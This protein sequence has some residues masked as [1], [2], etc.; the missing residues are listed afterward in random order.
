MPDAHRVWIQLGHAFKENGELSRAEVAY[1]TAVIKAPRVAAG[2]RELA[3]F[4]RRER[5]LREAELLA[6]AGLVVEPD[7]EDL[8]RELGELGVS[9]LKIGPTKDLGRLI[10][11]AMWRRSTNPRPSSLLRRA[12]AAARK[13]RWSEAATLY[14][15]LIER[16]PQDGRVCI[17]MAHALKEN[18]EI[19]AALGA[20]REAVDRDPLFAD[21]HL[22]LGYAL[23]RFGHED[24]ARSAL[25]NAFKLDPSLAGAKQALR[26]LAIDDA[27]AEQILH[28]AWVDPRPAPAPEP[29]PVVTH[30]LSNPVPP[31]HLAPR[32]RQ[33]WLGLAQN[34]LAN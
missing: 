12:R 30:L 20:Y 21:A 10:V 15:R 14:R 17:Q 29:Q 9:G 6:A 4:L 2:Y 31:G 11:Y 3:F 32:E 28:T 34:L 33:I 13:C 16:A 27:M 7:A 26:D 23:L 5:R 18:G 25:A 19:D 24:H 1:R 22:E 8:L